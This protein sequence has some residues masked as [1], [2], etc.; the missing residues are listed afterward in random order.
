LNS[1]EELSAQFDGQGITISYTAWGA[2]RYGFLAMQY[3][4]TSLGH[5]VRAYVTMLLVCHL[6]GKPLYACW[7]DAVEDYKHTKDL[8]KEKPSAMNEEEHMQPVMIRFC[9]CLQQAVKSEFRWKDTHR[10]APNLTDPK[11]FP[12]MTAMALGQ[13][14]W[15]YVVSHL[16]AYVLW[17]HELHN[18]CQ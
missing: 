8:G 4:V 7:R 15:F 17:L 5:D 16:F 18:A 13:Y 12:D 10:N 3:V 9:I 14:S 6:A 1:V 11:V 2:I